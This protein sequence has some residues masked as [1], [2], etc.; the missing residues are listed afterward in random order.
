MTPAAA[1]ADLPALGPWVLVNGRAVRTADGLCPLAALMRARGKLRRS[2]GAGVPWE[3]PEVVTAAHALGLSE[4]DAEVLADA[5]DDL[6][7][8]YA[9]NGA[10]DHGRRV[11]GLRTELLAACGLLKE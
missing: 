7:G 9:R 6:G 1:L 10:K 8:M 11:D 3:V 5:A 2:V 4:A